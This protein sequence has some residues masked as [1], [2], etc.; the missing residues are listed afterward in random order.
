MM[1]KVLASAVILL[2]P[3]V[4]GQAVFAGRPHQ[5]YTN[6][7]QEC[8]VNQNVNT[9]TNENTN[10]PTNENTNTP[11]N[12]NVNVNVTPPVVNTNV[13]EVL[14]IP[15]VDTNIAVPIVNTP[16][17]TFVVTNTEMLEPPLD[18][19]PETGLATWK[20]VLGFVVLVAGALLLF[21]RRG[22]E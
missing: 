20:F 19:L 22:G 4:V 2:I 6:T 16:T 18:V 15:V 5:S 7:K 17:E 10:V 21:A 12:E 9:P 13:P 14:N 11:V 8:Q 1:K 3:L